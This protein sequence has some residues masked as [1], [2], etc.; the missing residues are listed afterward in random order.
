MSG[1]GD[2]LAAGVRDVM[3]QQD[4][5]E[6]KKGASQSP[7]KTATSVAKSA[8]TRH[9]AARKTAARRPATAQAPATSSNKAAEKPTASSSAR[10]VPK[11]RARTS[12]T[13][14]SPAHAT[15]AGSVVKNIDTDSA[16]VAVDGKAGRVR[17]QPKFPERV[18]PD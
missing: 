16:E 12:Q 5:S 11:H 18:W 3:A 8:A 15:R 4:G 14:T 9:P 13:K 2:K 6:E 7:E 17:H 10:P 1:L